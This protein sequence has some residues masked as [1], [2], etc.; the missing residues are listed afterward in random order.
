M[1][2]VFTASYRVR[3]YETD[4]LRRVK[5]ATLLNYLQ[6]AASSHAAVLG[7]SVA[8]L[9]QKNLTWVLSR[10]QVR[11]YRYPFEGEEIRVRTWRSAVDSFHALRDF[12]VV[13]EYDRTLAVASSSWLII[14]LDSRRPV[15]IK[16]AVDDFP[17][18]PYRSFP[19]DFCM[20]PKC[21][22]SERE[23]VF[24]VR[25]ADLDQNRHVNHVVYPEWAFETIPEAVLNSRLPA[26]IH[27]AYRAEAVYG[28]KIISRSAVTDLPD[29]AT[30]LHQIIDESDGK[31]LARLKTVWH[32]VDSLCAGQINWDETE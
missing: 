16:T 25:M 6:D 29:T 1:E 7:F 11:V 5:P 21:D 10:Y 23:L 28:S 12:E 22:A 13:D 2:T 32:P 3:S 19:G 20:L 14:N 4:F 26:E 31:E 9:L 30:Y 27:I 18:H 17:V 24:R 8:D 15:R